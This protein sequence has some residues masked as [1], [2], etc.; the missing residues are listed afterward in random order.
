MSIEHGHDEHFGTSPTN[1]EL[2]VSI[3]KNYGV[4]NPASPANPELR[5]SVNHATLLADGL[6]ADAEAGRITRQEL[7]Q[8]LDKLFPE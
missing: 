4:H 8:A 7:E 3:G 5:V 2:L 6:M 1:S